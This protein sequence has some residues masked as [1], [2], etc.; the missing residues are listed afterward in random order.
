M[1]A[2]I[3]HALP[4]EKK[5]EKF[6]DSVSNETNPLSLLLSVL[7]SS[8]GVSSLGLRAVW[9]PKEEKASPLAAHIHNHSFCVTSCPTKWR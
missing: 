7:V 3:A 6:Q 1:P 8:V 2:D 9:R 5:Q 4:E